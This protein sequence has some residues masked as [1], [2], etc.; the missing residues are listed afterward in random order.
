MPWK[1]FFTDRHG[2]PYLGAVSFGVA[3]LTAEEA[4]TFQRRVAAELEVIR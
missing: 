2:N 3:E 4:Q 1:A